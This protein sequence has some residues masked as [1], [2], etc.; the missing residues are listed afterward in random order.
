MKLKNKEKEK[1]EIIVNSKKNK[2]ILTKGFVILTHGSFH[3]ANIIHPEI[4]EYAKYE[5]NLFLGL[6]QLALRRVGLGKIG[7]SPL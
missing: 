1:D 5:Q 7:W 4:E 3:G 2:I 6:G